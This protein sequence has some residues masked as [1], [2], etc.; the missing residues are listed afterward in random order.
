M[1]EL[2]RGIAISN[3]LIQYILLILLVGILITEYYK[4][5]KDNRKGVLAFLLLSMGITIFIIFDT[6]RFFIGYNKGIFLTVLMGMNIVLL[7]FFVVN[8][9]S[10]WGKINKKLF[11][12]IPVFVTGIIIFEQ[13]FKWFL[14][15]SLEILNTVA[16]GGATI[17]FYFL[18]F[19][20]L[21]TTSERGIESRKMLRRS[22]SLKKV[23]KQ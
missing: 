14:D 5:K 4:R 20:F 11:F 3:Y 7:S 18:V 17:L 13:M 16:M 19:K 1:T 8:C 10:V 12:I 15:I 21:I 23:L 6:Y 22:A 9:V 2:I